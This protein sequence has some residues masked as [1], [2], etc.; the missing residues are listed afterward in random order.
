MDPNAALIELVSA[1]MDGDA[2]TLEERAEALADWLRKD[3]FRPA[4]FALVLELD[5]AAF[6][7]D[8]APETARILEGLAEQ[9]RTG[10]PF[11]SLQRLRDVNG[12][13]VGRAILA[14]R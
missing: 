2:D 5:N 9:L 11:S 3:G 6:H 8:A 12:N 1:A 4:G 14:D 7:P 10:R 13:T